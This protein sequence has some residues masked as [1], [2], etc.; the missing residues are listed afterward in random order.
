MSKI[1]VVFE[2]AVG[3]VILILRVLVVHHWGTVQL[4]GKHV[5]VSE[6]D[7]IFS[8]SVTAEM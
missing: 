7:S 2:S 5:L 8:F 4:L 1:V 3:V 6:R